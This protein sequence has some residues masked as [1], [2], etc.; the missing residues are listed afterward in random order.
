MTDETDRRAKFIA[1][2]QA[3]HAHATA[4]T[5]AMING[6]GNLP[7]LAEMAGVQIIGGADNPAREGLVALYIDNV[8]SVDVV[9]ALNAQGIRTRLG[10]KP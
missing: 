10:Q 5:D 3:I 4:L 7:G 6:T 1:A 2:G 8:A 9:S